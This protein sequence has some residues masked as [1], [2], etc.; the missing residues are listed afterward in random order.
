MQLLLL[1]DVR[2]ARL[3]EIHARLRRR[4]G[5]QGP[6]LLLDPVSQLVMGLI[7]GRTT[8]E[9]SKAAFKKLRRRFGCWEAVRDAP[10]AEVHAAIAEVTFAELK[11]PRLKA[12][13]EAVTSTRG[14][15]ALD[16]LESLGV[17]DAL[18]WL[19]R[20]PG[21]GRKTAAATLNFSSLRRAALVIDTHHL[22]ILRRLGLVDRHAD[23]REAYDRIMPLL[24]PSWTAADLDQHHQLMKAL[25]QTF[26]P[27]GMPLCPRC[28]LQD[29]CPTAPL[30]PA[31]YSRLLGRRWRREP[32][33][34]LRLEPGTDQRGRPRPAAERAWRPGP[35]CRQ[36]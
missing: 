20:L 25:G 8:G 14:R 26:C 16:N 30:R 1:P 34:K 15:L 31:A 28:P 17:E 3:A 10:V 24:P 27:H 35:T 21:V 11:A 19:E 36:R 9:A 4:F 13:L 32:P 6:F 5:P 12:A 22:R 33:D 23:Y 2:A 18:A 7:G 29:L